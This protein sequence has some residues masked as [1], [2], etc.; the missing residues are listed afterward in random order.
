MIG[1]QYIG[2][3]N[4]YLPTHYCEEGLTGGEMKVLDFIKRQVAKTGYAINLNKLV[5]E[6]G[7]YHRRFDTNTWACEPLLEL[8]DRGAVAAV[9][10]MTPAFV[11]DLP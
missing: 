3:L 1:I 8:I 7:H 5:D 4:N 11:H 6:F 9:K 10:N 2:G